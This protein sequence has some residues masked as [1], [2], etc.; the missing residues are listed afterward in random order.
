[1]VD[2]VQNGLEPVGEE[3]H[4][5]KGQLVSDG[6]NLLDHIQHPHQPQQMEDGP[7]PE[8]VQTMENVKGLGGCE[9]GNS[10]QY[11]DDA[12]ADQ[13]EDVSFSCF[14]HNFP[15]LLYKML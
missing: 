9:A 13:L 4:G 10:T 5:A 3:L 8:E 2:L 15:L 7:T 1:M 14:G 11:Q 12:S 6:Q